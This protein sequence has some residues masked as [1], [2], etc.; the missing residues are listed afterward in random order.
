MG[1]LLLCSGGQQKPIVASLLQLQTVTTY[2]VEILML[3]AL[4]LLWRSASRWWEEGA[5]F[6]L[7]ATQFISSVLL[8]WLVSA[9]WL[10]YASIGSIP[11]WLVRF[12][13]PVAVLFHWLTLGGLCVFLLLRTLQPSRSSFTRLSGGLLAILCVARLVWTVVAVLQRGEFEPG[14]PVSALA[15]IDTSLYVA[16]F[17][18]LGHSSSRLAISQSPS[19][20]HRSHTQDFRVF[21]NLRILYPLLALF[22]LFCVLQISGVLFSRWGQ[23]WKLHSIVWSI[24]PWFGLLL[25]LLLL[26]WFGHLSFVSREL[27]ISRWFVITTMT[28]GFILAL[29]TT[30]F[31]LQQR[32][33]VIAPMNHTFS[34]SSPVLYLFVSSLLMGLVG[35]LVFLTALKHTALRYQEPALARKTGNLRWIILGY[36]IFAPLPFVLFISLATHRKLYWKGGAGSIIPYFV[37]I[38]YLVATVSL[39]SLVFLNLTGT[40]RTLHRKL[41]VES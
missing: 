19:P 28:V 7:V 6:L 5:G 30:A 9:T 2:L 38:C 1:L 33:Y 39:L 21:L 20:A 37:A 16:Y 12:G 29:A 40:I 35:V 34:V 11:S 3:L 25:V 36:S 14:Y 10:E 26:F 8:L 22:L 13:H 17:A 23:L 31:G 27:G 32:T 4:L 41:K 18:F 15:W 24:T